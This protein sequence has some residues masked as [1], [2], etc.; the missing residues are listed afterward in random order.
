MPTDDSAEIAKFEAMAQEWWDPEGRFKPLHQLN[1]VRVDYIRT[2]LAP[3]EARNL[4]GLEIL[5][6]GCGGGILAESLARLKAQVVGIDRSAKIIGVAK[7]R[8]LETGTT[9][10]YRVQ[11]VDELARERPGSFDAVM[12]MEVL[13]HVPVPREFLAEGVKLLKPNGKLFFSTLNRTPKA[14]LLAIAGAEYLLR[15]LPRGTHQFE[16]FIRP[17]ELTADLRANGVRVREISGMI[18]HPLRREWSLGPDLAVNYL[19]YGTRD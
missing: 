14:W 5:D 9:I 1:P 4:A 6:I 18:Y 3:P 2:R 17:S 12:A 13:E 11:S 15:W 19:G 7:A 8:Q 16:R 10:D